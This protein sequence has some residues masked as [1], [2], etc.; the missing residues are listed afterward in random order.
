MP[1]GRLELRF[2][3]GAA[4]VGEFTEVI[5]ERRLAFTWSRPGWPAPSTVTVELEGGMVRVRHTGLPPDLE[6]LY[7]RTWAAAL[8]SLGQ[9]AAG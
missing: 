3:G 9:A 7:R 4:V 6:E 8:E 1:G 5:P 2:P